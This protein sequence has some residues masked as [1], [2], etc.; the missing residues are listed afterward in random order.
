MLVFICVGFV[1]KFK[2]LLF[3]F[4]FFAVPT[5]A[6]QQQGFSNYQEN[7][8]AVDFVCTNQC[9]I[10]LDAGS[11]VD[12]LHVA[13]QLQWQGTFGYGFL[14]WQQVAPGGVLQ[15][16]WG[17]MLDTDFVFSQS[18]V[19]AQLPA[20][21]HIVILVNGNV[22]WSHVSFQTTSYSLF[23]RIGKW[24]DD[25]RKMEP[26]TPYSINLRYGVQI[27]GT[28][29]VQ[30][31]YIIFLLA[32][33]YILVFG[34]WNK[35]K[36]FRS[37]F[38]RGIGIFL[39]IGFRNLITYTWIVDQWL[40]MY[41]YQTMENKTYFDLWDYIP[42]TD[43]IRKTL[44]LDEG[45]KSCTIAIH[46]AQDWPFIPHWENLYLKPCTVV[47]TGSEADYLIYYKK[48]I[49]SWDLQKPVLVDFNGSYLL[50]NK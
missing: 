39:F 45:N 41:T 26:M 28:S 37:V 16:N 8:A 44:G 15:I 22:Q 40:Q 21:Y 13:W 12:A 3:L 14:V 50:Q 38:F 49:S 5:F 43:K 31:G 27:L 11:E 33:L 1:M 36:K 7:G 19:F 47:L 18:P 35:H 29:I 42:F 6:Y 23:Q 48:A 17:G 4:V 2:R 9:A 32:A 34:K 10:L 24:W 25:F 46:S 20:G 30:Y